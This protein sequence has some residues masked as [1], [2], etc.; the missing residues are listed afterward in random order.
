[1]ARNPNLQVLGVAGYYDLATPVG[2]L[3]YNL[4][5][6]GYDET[7]IR[8]VGITYYEGGH[9]MYIRPSAH[10]QLKDDIT[11]FIRQASRSGAV[12]T[13]TR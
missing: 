7:F 5:H 2:G 11:R 9:M 6:L 10:A 8:R 12:Q 4:W 3:E 1:M 13:S